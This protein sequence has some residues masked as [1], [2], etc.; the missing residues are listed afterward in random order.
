VAQ[1][2][3][4][5]QVQHAPEAVLVYPAA[6]AQPLDAWVN[7]IHVRTLAF[8]LDRGLEAAGQAFVEALLEGRAA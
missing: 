1:V 6:P 2:L 7:G 5:A 4:Y 8:A 3:A